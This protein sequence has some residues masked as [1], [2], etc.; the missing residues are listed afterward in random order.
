MRPESRRV[1]VLSAVASFAGLLA[2]AAPAPDA[3]PPAA[4]AKVSMPNPLRGSSLFARENLVAWCIVPFDSKKRGPKER[5]EMLLRLGI[6]RMAYDWRNNHVPQWDEEM[7][8]YKKN[9]IELVGFWTGDARILDLMKRQQMTTQLWISGGGNTVEAAAKGLA[10]VA[11]RAKEHGCSIGLYNHGGWFGEPENQ[12]GIIEA[13]RAQG[14]QNVGIVY[15]LHHAHHRMKDFPEM[16]KKMTPY[17]WCLNLNGMKQ[18]TKILPIGQGEDDLGI[19]KAIVASGYRGPIGIL[20]HLDID[21]DVG[22][23]QNIEGLKKLLGQLGDEAALK[24][25]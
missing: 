19:L 22:L 13:M 10:G 20:N 23:T 25:Y 12:I 1:V 2:L 16:L 24:T 14:H 7:E 5:V 4:A 15:N 8:L 18:G 6:K 3:S 11:Q 9:G 21:A 17:L